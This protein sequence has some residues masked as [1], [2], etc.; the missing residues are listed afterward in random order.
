[1]LFIK[2]YNGFFIFF[3]IVSNILVLILPIHLCYAEEP[4]VNFIEIKGVKRIEEGAVRARL[5]QKTNEPLSRDK[6]ASDIKSIYQMGY[7]DNVRVEIDFFEG[8]LKLIYNVSEKPTII[9]IAFNGN[10]EFDDDKLKEHTTIVTGSI[11]DI[12]LIQDNVLSLK[13]FYEDEGYYLAEIFPIV[14]YVSESEVNITFEI[15]EGDKIKIKTVKITGNQAISDKQIRKA[16][17]IRRWWLFSFLTGSGYVKK[18]VLKDDVRRIMDLYYNHGYIDV[19]VSEPR[20]ELSG[21]KKRLIVSLEVSEGDQYRISSVKTEGFHVFP[22]EQ[23]EEMIALKKGELFNKK[24]LGETIKTLTE[25]YSEK[26]YAL[27]SI[28]PQ[29]VPNKKE[30]TVIVGLHFD[31]GSLYKIG[32]IEITGN[33]ITRDK[34]IRRDVVL[35]EGDIFNS[36][37]I[38]RSYQ[39]LNNLNFFETVELLPRPQPE[40]DI[41]DIDIKVKEKRTGFINLGGGYS[42]IDKFVA[43]IQL[44]QTN[45]FGRG[46]Y[47]QINAELGGRGSLYEISFREPWFLDR[48]ISF[49]LSIFRTER[50]FIDYSRKA[51]GGSFGFGKRFAEYWSAGISYK[52]EDVTVF[53]VA[54]N[55][56]SRIREQEGDSTTSSITTSIRRD[57]R[58]NFL[59]PTRGS[60]NS[61]FVTFAGLGG[62]NAFLK[63]EIDSL[64][65]YPIDP[66]TISLRGR[67][68]YA[69]GILDKGLPIFERF[70]VG[71]INTVRG[72]NLGE[73]GPRDEAGSLIGGTKELIFNTE[74]IF[75]IYKEVRLKGVLF[76]DAGNAYDKDVPLGPLRYTTGAGVRWLSPFGPIRI[77]YGFNLDRREGEES[78]KVEFAFGS[79]F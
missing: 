56:S 16:M 43:L 76:F 2:N 62:T 47:V 23:I 75:P 41:V 30:K 4:L 21:D 73:A 67:L 20:I 22:G 68:G 78:G 64:W 46:Q 42:S 72:L 14:H 9:K 29:L 44:T 13:K 51:I 48:P 45:L 18:D 5:T 71:G 58:D 32:R 59:D 34:V 40:E 37:K 63:G 1:M 53:N 25:F 69:T 39:K 55:A 28:T 11:A 60:R 7:F 3:K 27:I 26:G 54:E 12:T 36:K 50:E 65:F 74:L 79:A 19:V 10:E 66:V 49:T 31:E 15:R 57:T 52:Y 24:V 33:T 35:N 17:K 38:K 8:G 61:L 77:E 6:I 70:L